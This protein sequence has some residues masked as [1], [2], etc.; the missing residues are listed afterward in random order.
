MQKN[1]TGKKTYTFPRQPGKMVLHPSIDMKGYYDATGHMHISMFLFIF[2]FFKSQWL[3]CPFM[4]HHPTFT[5]IKIFLYVTSVHLSRGV[6]LGTGCDLLL[7]SC[8]LHHFPCTRVAFSF[9]QLSSKELITGLIKIWPFSH[10]GGCF[11]WL[12]HITH[13]F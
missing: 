9:L 5:F 8:P 4:F 3:K 2:V 12:S 6:E 13:W 11:C 1:S 10:N 7:L